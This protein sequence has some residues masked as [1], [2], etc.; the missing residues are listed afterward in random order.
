MPERL[1][2]TSGVYREKTEGLSPEMRK[3]LEKSMRRN[4]KL[5][6]RQYRI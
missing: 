1:V 4:N 3:R 6:K 5:M 2:S